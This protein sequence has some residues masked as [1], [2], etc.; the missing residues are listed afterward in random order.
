MIAHCLVDKDQP[1]EYTFLSKLIII[2]INI[3]TTHSTMEKV[4]LPKFS[5]YLSLYRKNK[6]GKSPHI[7]IPYSP[8]NFLVTWLP[9][10]IS[11]RKDELALPLAI[12]KIINW[13]SL[14]IYQS[15]VRS[16]EYQLYLEK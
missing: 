9:V 16:V 3:G 10:C 4:S 15:P 2:K 7:L 14:S 1:L 6:Y 8:N 5:A 11:K 12:V 13:H